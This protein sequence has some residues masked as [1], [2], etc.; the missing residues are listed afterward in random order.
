MGTVKIGEDYLA[1]V[2]PDGWVCDNEVTALD[3]D[4]NDDCLVNLE[5]FAIF[6]GV[7]L[8]SNRIEIEFSDE[9]NVS[10]HCGSRKHFLAAYVA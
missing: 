3:Y 2:D 9:F 4:Y 10:G 1:S 8:D 7:W 5:D 6:A